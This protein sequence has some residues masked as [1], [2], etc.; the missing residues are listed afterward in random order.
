MIKKKDLAFV[1]PALLVV[2]LLAYVST[3]GKERFIPR[4][5][6]HEA[7]IGIEDRAQADAYCFSCHDPAGPKEGAPPMPPLVKETDK[8][9]APTM[10]E[11]GP[12]GKRHPIRTKNCRLCHRLE[13]KP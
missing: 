10:G 12:G 7:A 9:P 5:P 8:A 1:I 2:G 4:I 6:A 3:K 11:E 13:R